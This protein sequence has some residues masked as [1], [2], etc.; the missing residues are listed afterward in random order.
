MVAFNTL[1][2]IDLAATPSVV[3]AIS[4]DRRT[5]F[6]GRTLYWDWNYVA[7]R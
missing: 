7:M 1:T 3:L 5:E 2:T 6:R 4:V